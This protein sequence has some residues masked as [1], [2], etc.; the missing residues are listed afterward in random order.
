MD[1]VVCLISYLIRNST[2][3][4]L[5]QGIQTIPSSIQYQSLT[6]LMNSFLAM[7]VAFFPTSMSIELTPHIWLGRHS[8]VLQQC[9][10]VA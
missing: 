2:D 7:V 5:F 3:L 4:F 1:R 10:P 8:C 9:D 6:S